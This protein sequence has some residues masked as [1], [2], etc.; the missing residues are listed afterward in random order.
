MAKNRRV[1]GLSSYYQTKECFSNPQCPKLGIIPQ[2]TTVAETPTATDSSGLLGFA[3]I[4]LR[5][6]KAG[7]TARQALE[8]SRAQVAA[9]RGLVADEVGWQRLEEAARL[10][11]F[12]SWL[13]T[14]WPHSFDELI[15]CAPL[16]Q[17]VNWECQRCPVGQRQGGVSCANPDSLFGRIGVL[18]READRPGLAAYLETVE[19]T[20]ADCAESDGGG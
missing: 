17:R 11:A 1:Y 20:L 16:C 6:Q 14:D 15:V 3:D 10:R 4:V 5:W 2:R 7:G 18:L 19:R 8:L 13:V 9:V 12:D